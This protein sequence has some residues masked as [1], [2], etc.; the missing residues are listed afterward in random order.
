MIKSMTGYGQSNV[1]TKCGKVFI[2]IQSVNRKH[3]E[4]NINVP[5]D[6]LQLEND[7]RKE[8]E[9]HI[10]RGKINVYVY[11]ERSPS[12]TKTL[13]INYTVAQ[14]YVDCCNSLKKKFKLKG[15]IDISALVSSKDVLSYNEIRI[16]S[17]TLAKPLKNAMRKSLLSLNQMRSV[18]GKALETDLKKRLKAIKNDL[19]I[20]KKIT[21]RTVNEY[22]RKL[23]KRIK[24]YAQDKKID[25]Q[26]S[27][28]AALFADK[29]DVSEEIVR[30]QS[31]LGQF[32]S[33][34]R[35][36]KPV[37]KTLDFIVQEMIRESNTIGSKANSVK[38]SQRVI[39]IKGEIEKLREQIQNIE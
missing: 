25:E 19:E 16:D 15:D 5:R 29:V 3:L 34:L 12:Y 39:R 1:R 24:K 33:M 22:E 13:N 36:K 35:M 4:I 37:G 32:L 30:L 20:I 38:T 17:T 2:Q 27:K 11:F 28:E 21:P 26:I 7:L 10:E 23:R 8:I 31:H 14:K 6:I 18:E 9:A